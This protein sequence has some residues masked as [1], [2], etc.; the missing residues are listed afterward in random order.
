MKKIFL[1]LLVIYLS[2]CATSYQKMGFSGG[3]EETQL[4]PNVWKVHFAGNG[5]TRSSRAED[6]TL[7]RS[8]DITL[9]N[10]FSYFVLA[11][12]NSSTDYSSYTAPSTSVTNV[13]MYGN[14]GTGTTNTYGG[15]THIISK[16]S[17]TNT[18]VM[19][20]TKPEMPTIIYDASFICSSLGAKYEVNCGAVK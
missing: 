8:A 2:G 10:G 18:V 9:Q 20:K 14:S 13:N 3:F 17:T 5:Y 19:Y 6:M 11:G 4:A 7:L 12:S 15:G 16:P 1:S